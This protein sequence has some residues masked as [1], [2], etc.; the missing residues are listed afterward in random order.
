MKLRHTI[1]SILFSLLAFGLVSSVTA[2]A[3]KVGF[4]YVG[5]I[6]DHGWTY[7][8]DRGRLAAESHFGDQIETTY[9]ES[10]QEGADSERVI[11]NLARQGYGLI[12]TTSFGYMEPTLRVAKTFPK[13]KFEHISGYKRSGNVATNNIRYYEGRYVSGLVA[14]ELTES[15]TVGYVASFPIPEVIRGINAFTIGLRERNPDADVR[16]IWVN[17]WFD[18]GKEADA[19]KALIAQ[20]ADVLLQHTDSPAVMQTAENS[21]VLAVGQA[22]DMQAYGNNAQ[23]TAAVNNWGPYYIMRIQQVMDGDWQSG[24]T[25]EGLSTD[26]L[27][28]ADWGPKVPANVRQIG[29]DAIAGIKAGTLHPFTGEIRWQDG[30][31]AVAAGE[32][33]SDGDLLSMNRYVQGVVGSV[34]K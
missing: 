15:N 5:P 14:G 23:I 28:M 34:P 29:N 26:A 11:R 22:S 3:L 32:T 21:G 1:K 9:I 8:H 13:V 19:A 7:Q 20:G 17:S 6:G 31:V 33:M 16:V 27:T 12:F 2:D 10:V 25:W 18:P 30:S 4:V 24:D